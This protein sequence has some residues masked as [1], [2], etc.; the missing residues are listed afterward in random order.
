MI[1]G[2]NK[3]ILEVSFPENKHFEKALVFLRSSSPPDSVNIYDEAEITVS[4]LEKELDIRPGR[5]FS[6]IKKAAAD[7]ITLLFKLSVI[8]CAA[9]AVINFS[10]Q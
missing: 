1:K 6:E 4:G 8:I 5:S 3:R 9:A 10:A 7:I 2:V